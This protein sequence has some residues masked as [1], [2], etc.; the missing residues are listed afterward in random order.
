[1]MSPSVALDEERERQPEH[2]GE[3]PGRH[4]EIELALDVDQQHAP[5]DFGHQPEQGD[6]REC[7]RKQEKDAGIAARNDI[8]DRDLQVPRRHQQ[9]RLH[10]HRQQ[11]DLHALPDHRAGAAEQLCQ[12]QAPLPPLRRKVFRLG[13]F[14]R[15]AGEMIRHLLDRQPPHAAG[16]IVDHDRAPPHRFEDDEMVHVPV[17]HRRHPEMG[18]MLRFEPQGASLES[19][20]F[21]HQRHG[22][23][24][25]PV[26]RGG[27]AE[28]QG[29]EIDPVP[30]PI[31]DHRQASVP[32]LGGFGLTDQ[33]KVAKAGKHG[34]LMKLS[35]VTAAP[36]R[37]RFRRSSR[38]WSAG[39]FR[40]SR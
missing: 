27:V 14:H 21:G 34:S 2:V 38:G 30:E 13:E 37:T 11:D 20:L 19:E 4:R 29:N 36:P 1:M 24:A 23:D 32:A 39:R 40:S 33:R 26:R 25:Q 9:Q 18:E 31:G 16:G 8:V 7:T 35:H 6:D 5:R 12:R 10:E 3:H 22:M 15:N 17:Q 28:P